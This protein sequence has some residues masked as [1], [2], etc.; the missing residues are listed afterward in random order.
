MCLLTGTYLLLVANIYKKASGF[1]WFCHTSGC[2]PSWVHSWHWVL[3]A[4]SSAPPLPKAASCWLRLWKKKGQPPYYAVS[5]PLRTLLK[6]TVCFL[7]CIL[8]EALESNVPPVRH[9]LRKCLMVASDSQG[10]QYFKPRTK[11]WLKQQRCNRPS[12]A[13]Q[14]CLSH[15]PLLLFAFE[16]IQRLR[17]GKR[18]VHRYNRGSNRTVRTGLA[19]NFLSHMKR[20]RLPLPAF[21]EC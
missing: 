3:A 12:T 15:F 18:I 20:S 21:P 19:C 4:E 8:L 2:G 14:Y 13:C 16:V 1:V 5:I 7:F 9:W 17:N 11:V 10:S 6:P